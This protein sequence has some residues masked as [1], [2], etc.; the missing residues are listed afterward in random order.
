M[1]DRDINKEEKTERKEG[2][3]NEEGEDR[4]SESLDFTFGM[5]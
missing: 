2:H 5:S 1:Q 3:T 4:V